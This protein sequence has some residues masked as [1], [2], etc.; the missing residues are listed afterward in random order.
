LAARTHSRWHDEGIEHSLEEIAGA[1]AYLAWKTAKDRAINLH[2]ENFVYD[3]DAQRLAVI[4]EYL[5]FQV[6][7]VDRLA[8]RILADQ[9][10]RQPLITGIAL[11]IADYMQDN[12]T[13]MLG[14][15]DYRGE[16]IRAFNTRSQ[17]YAELGFSEDGPSYPFLRHLGFEIQGVM[18]ERRE[19]RWVIDQVMDQDGPEIARQLT[20]VLAD[21]LD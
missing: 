5:C 15:G 17:D 21:L 16:F 18:G 2:G 4:R 11:R 3:S 1:L 19:N 6:Q 8:H 20:R 13:D 12:G 7:V 9:T 14:P 10:L